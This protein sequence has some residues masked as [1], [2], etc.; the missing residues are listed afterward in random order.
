MSDSKEHGHF[1]LAGFAFQLLG[2]GAEAFE[3][4]DDIST[5]DEANLPDRLLVLEQHGQDTVVTEQGKTKQLNQYKYSS[6][7]AEIQPSELREILVKFLESSEFADTPIEDLSFVLTT[8][9]TL[10]TSAQSLWD[11]KDNEEIEERDKVEQ[12]RKA[13]KN[14]SKK[15][16]DHLPELTQIFRK[17]KSNVKDF[18]D[19]ADRLKS[20]AKDFGVLDEE[21]P[22]AIDEIIGLLLRTS[23]KP[24]FRSVYRLDI[25]KALTGFSNPIRLWSA[26]SKGIRRREI[27]N[28]HE[29]AA[30]GCITIQR[31]TVE[32]VASH[33]LNHPVVVV[34]GNGGC[35]KS[36]LLGDVALACHEDDDSMRKF[37]YLNSAS[38]TSLAHL[39]DTISQWRN[40]MMNSDGQNL[41]RS[42]TRLSGAC[43][44]SPRL[45]VLVDGIDE[46]LG[47]QYLP[48]AA[49]SFLQEAIRK[50]V[51]DYR[52]SLSWEIGF[53]L[54]CRDRDDLKDLRLPPSC[55]EQGTIKEISV[56]GFTNDEI[57]DLVFGLG[58]G[59]AQNRLLSHFSNDSF[60]NPMSPSQLPAVDAAVMNLLKSPVT[61]GAFTKLTPSEQDS[62]L[63]G[64]REAYD[65]LAEEILKW[66]RGKLSTRS[67]DVQRDACPVLLSAAARSLLNAAEP[68]TKKEHWREPGLTEGCT[69]MEIDA[70]FRELKSAGLITVIQSHPLTWKW[71]YSWFWDYLRRM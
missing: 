51:N 37:V 32:S 3:V 14:S 63:D 40:Q 19:F 5:S 35:G 11:I 18:R 69:T 58:P 15:A 71:T 26:S 28:F 47:K 16:V 61:W 44:A 20:E 45:L 25:E 33:L 57:R 62:L 46:T 54:N 39:I 43:S 27:D 30:D 8:N 2:A 10:S 6:T 59:R 42:V 53:I 17:L 67:S 4:Y 22:R 23:A 1:A 36:V 49:L 48:D 56:S 60:G 31:Q 12:I 50:S 66:F 52:E 41:V 68:A 64:N 29:I 9:R 7:A 70:L 55:F 38:R 13:I 21:M 24:R 65:R 34:T